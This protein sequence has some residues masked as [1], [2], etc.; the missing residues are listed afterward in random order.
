MI[1]IITIQHYSSFIIMSVV[2][3]ITISHIRDTISGLGKHNYPPLGR[4][5]L[6]KDNQI[7][8]SKTYKHN[9]DH[10]LEIEYSCISVN[11]QH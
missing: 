9:D 10:L 2:G 7:A 4:W 6:K 1:C 3:R 5:L 8:H 11:T